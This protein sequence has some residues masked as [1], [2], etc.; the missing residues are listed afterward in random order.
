MIPGIGHGKKVW[1]WK[2]LAQPLMW[3]KC[4]EERCCGRGILNTLSHSHLHHHH[5]FRWYHHKPLNMANLPHTYPAWQM[6]HQL[7][8]LILK[9]L[10]FR[11]RLRSLNLLFLP[12]CTPQLQT[13]QKVLLNQW[14]II[15]T[16]LAKGKEGQAR[17]PP[18]PSSSMDP[19]T[20]PQVPQQVTTEA[21][22]PQRRYPARN[23]WPP[24]RFWF[25]GGKEI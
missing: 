3:Y 15:Q 5:C 24:D 25:K 19:P 11:L 10:S 12:H 6:Y 20:L 7:N 18:V 16:H 2:E 9:V 8:W 17:I 22:I 13:Q 4:K 1:S 14:L 23:W 21:P